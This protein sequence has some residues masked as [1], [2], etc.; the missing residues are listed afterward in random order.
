MNI[1]P[2][3]STEALFNSPLALLLIFNPPYSFQ[4]PARHVAGRACYM[5][6]KS[7][8]MPREWLLFYAPKSARLLKRLSRDAPES[9]WSFRKAGV[10]VYVCQPVSHC[11]QRAG[12]TG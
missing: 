3:A 1:A 10:H 5:T 12:Q 2:S 9:V 6:T 7:T 11:V 4:R 8:C